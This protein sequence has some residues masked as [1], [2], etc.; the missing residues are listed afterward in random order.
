M[1]TVILAAGFGS[2]L[3]PV[4]TSEKPKQF[5]PLIDGKSLLRYTYDTLKNVIPENEIYVL[6]LSG[7][8]D[9]ILEQIPELNPGNIVLVPERRNTLPHTLWTIA[10]ITDN[11][12][13][14]VLFRS[15]DHYLPH[16]EAF[17]KSLKDVL[18]N[19]QATS[20]VTLLCPRFDKFNSNDGYA[21]T[22]D[23]ARITKFIEKPTEQE[24]SDLAQG[25]TVYRSPFIY[26]ASENSMLSNLRA[27]NEDWAAAAQGILNKELSA[28]KKAFLDMPF[29]DLSSAIF[30]RAKHLRVAEI[31]YEFIDVGLF[32]ELYRLN[33]KDANGNVIIGR[34]I[35]TEDCRDNLV[36]NT[37]DRPMVIINKQDT[38][39]VQTNDGS[40]VSTFADAARV[41]E[42][43]KNQIHK[44]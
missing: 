44:H 34:A 22:D 37:T 35:I 33:T 43:Y 28:R 13:E 38:V 1:K 12:D 7:M 21:I 24:V 26:I 8:T 30:Q 11:P 29:V 17:L 10:Q 25:R 41:G 16:P 5:Q 31:T 39:I 3:W 20:D 19:Y 9:L 4:S 2:R 36:I 18:D 6:G 42:I 15:V 27:L 40:L 32:K 23:Q 14:P